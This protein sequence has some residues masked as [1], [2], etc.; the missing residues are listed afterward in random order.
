MLYRLHHAR[1]LKR[2][3]ASSGTKESYLKSRL[4][5]SKGHV[6]KRK[7]F[8]ICIYSIPEII[9]SYWSHH[10]TLFNFLA[11]AICFSSFLSA[12]PDDLV[13]FATSVIVFIRLRDEAQLV[14]NDRIALV[15][16]GLKKN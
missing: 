11:S 3:F 15:S 8:M 6:G 10:G 12:A 16:R 2:E 1:A 13:L 5:K 14:R 7:E 4:V 9:R